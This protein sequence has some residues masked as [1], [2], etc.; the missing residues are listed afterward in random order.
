MIRLR[1]IGQC[2]IEVGDARLT[3]AAET[4]FATALYLVL[5][6]GRAVSRQE[7]TDM[8]WPL[9]SERRGQHCLRQALYKLNSLG[10]ALRCERVHIVLPNRS[11]HSDCAP[12]LMAQDPAELERLATEAAG[13]FLPGY[14]PTFSAPFSNWLDRQRDLMNSAIRRVLVA[15]LGARK[16]RGEWHMVEALATKCL[17][18]DPLNEEA[19]LAIA[20]AAAMQGSKVRALDLLDRYLREIGPEAREVRVPATVLRRRIADV[21]QA[22]PVPVRE[23]PHVGR[24]DQMAALLQTLRLASQGHGAVVFTH[25]EPGIGK[26]R[27]MTEFVRAASLQRAQIARVGCQ[28]HDERRPLSAFVD[29]VPKLLELRGSIGSS[30]ESIKYLKRLVAHNPHETTLSPDS[31]EAELL[32]ANIRRS[33]FDL[34]DSIATEGPL[35][36]LVE[37]VHWLDRMSWEL[38]RDVAGWV[39]TRPALLLLTSRVVEAAGRLSSSEHHRPT[40]LHLTPLQDA[41]ARELLRSV[42]AGTEREGRLDFQDWCV[43]SGAGNPYYLTELALH[44]S[45]NGTQYRAPATLAKLIADRLS[46]LDVVAK[47][48]LQTSCLLG[49]FS[50]LNLLETILGERR[51]LLVGALDELEKLGMIEVDG[52]HILC[53]HELL[54]SAAVDQLSRASRSLLHRH[55]ANA[56]EREAA[57]NE[58]TAILWECARHW[59]QA[60]ERERAIELLR[61]CARHSIEMGLPGEAVSLLEEAAALLTDNSEMLEVLQERAVALQLSDQWNDIPF[62]LD[63]IGS[64]RRQLGIEADSHTDEELLAIEATWHTQSKARELIDH[65]MSCARSSTASHPHRLRAATLAFVFADNICDDEGIHDFFNE[66][67][68]ITQL[69]SISEAGRSHLLMIFHSSF[70]DIMDAAAA[71]DRLLEQARQRANTAHLSRFL[72][73]AANAYYNAGML[74]HAER[75]ALESFQL[76]ERAQL[77]TACL[78]AAMTLMSFQLHS[79]DI[80]GAAHW[81]AQSR[82][83]QHKISSPVVAIILL[84]LEARIALGRNDF[85]L[86][87]D[88]ILKHEYCL[89]HT[90]PPRAQKELLALRTDL[91]LRRGDAIPKEHIA[92]MM[93][94]H[95]KTRRFLQ[96]DYF[97]SVMLR[98]LDAE[99]LTDLGSSLLTEYTRSCRRERCPLPPSLAH[100]RNMGGEDTSDCAEP[101]R[102]PLVPFIHSKEVGGDAAPDHVIDVPVADNDMLRPLD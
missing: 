83:W 18:L 53:K 21:Y 28:S 54:A 79:E 61:S 6:S 4:L 97:V 1:S 44:A 14:A 29:L 57:S 2:I 87:E 50:T 69:N 56:L 45:W 3:P 43:S 65:A 42:T 80:D 34:L 5:E 91:W 20:E 88:L 94:H 95:R 72:R 81:L 22:V 39:T 52:A 48:V 12:F 85:A 86:A 26:T 13:P 9:A 92:L 41:A 98:F 24:D 7:L 30:P 74:G 59:Q 63:R 89:P 58:S 82:Q 101:P 70:G 19:T 71:A 25:G 64:L 11:V 17:G 37:D 27:L 93:E 23:A 31:R 46:R 60:G 8:V 68:P 32:F 96:H 66:I 49:K 77:P 99:G 33:V 67:Y 90:E 51:I 47:R 73:H 102:R 16:Q 100:R 38:L 75:A 55:A 76:A 84:S 35:V 36:I 15:A 10:A 78:G 62:V 40:L